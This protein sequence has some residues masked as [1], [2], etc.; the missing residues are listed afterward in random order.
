K[1]KTEEQLPETWE[2]QKPRLIRDQEQ[3]KIRLYVNAY[4]AKGYI[5]ARLGQLEDAKI[6]TQRV[7]EID[8]KRESS[9][10]TVFEVLTRSPEEDE[11]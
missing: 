1:I 3:P 6:I 9:A 10:T 7:Q 2:E 11:E 8:T 4:A 5:L